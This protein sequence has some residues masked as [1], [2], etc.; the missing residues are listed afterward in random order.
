MT[1]QIDSDPQHRRT[2]EGDREATADS[3][4]WDV[5]EDTEIELLSS[6]NEPVDVVDVVDES[7]APGQ[8]PPGFRTMR[9]S[10]STR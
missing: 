1:A 3:A 8:P 9:C 10:T 2:S 5:L 6:G 4:T 7:W